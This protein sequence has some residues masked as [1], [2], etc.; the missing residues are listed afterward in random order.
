VESQASGRFSL[1]VRRRISTLQTVVNSVLSA[2]EHIKNLKYSGDAIR[3][4]T[5]RLRTEVDI[6]RRCD[7]ENRIL[8]SELRATWQHLQ[9][10]DPNN[11]HVF[12]NFT[13]QLAHEQPQS[14]AVPA[15]ILPP[16]QQPGQ[17][18]PQPPVA[19]QGVEYPPGQGYDHR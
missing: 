3:R 4:D 7:E 13:N 15:T 10:V 17:W 8:R 16:L 2:I 18:P 11:A 9:R 6:A 14:A 5:E 12:G 19:M 1:K